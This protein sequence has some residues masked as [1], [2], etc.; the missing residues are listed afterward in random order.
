MNSAC[1]ALLHE[2]DGGA[3]LVRFGARERIKFDAL[4]GSH[5]KRRMGVD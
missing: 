3:L 1:L 4:V 5:S 2:F